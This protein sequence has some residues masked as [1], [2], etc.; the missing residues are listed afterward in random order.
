MQQ[1]L[2]ETNQKYKPGLAGLHY[3]IGHIRILQGQ[4]TLAADHFRKALEYAPNGGLAIEIKQDLQ[5]L[6]ETP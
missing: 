6:A 1:A 3:R 4:S 2:R 5:K